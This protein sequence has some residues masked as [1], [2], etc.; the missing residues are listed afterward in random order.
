MAYPMVTALEQADWRGAYREAG[1]LVGAVYK[2]WSSEACWR[3]PGGA[4]SGHR[5]IGGDRAGGR[6]RALF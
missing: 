1:D 6:G 2:R 4:R 5:G 3:G